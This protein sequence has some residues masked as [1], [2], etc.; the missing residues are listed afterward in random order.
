VAPGDAIS[1][2]A[3]LY[4]EKSG[5]DY[6]KVELA[7]GVNDKFAVLYLNGRRQIGGTFG[8]SA[9]SAENQND[10]YFTGTGVISATPADGTLIILN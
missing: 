4:L 6:G 10:D 5:E 7:D 8:S 3:T 2:D 1:D 9:S